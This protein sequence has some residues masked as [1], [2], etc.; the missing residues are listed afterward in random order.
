MVGALALAGSLGRDKL[1]IRLSK[2]IMASLFTKPTSVL[3]GWKVADGRYASETTLHGTPPAP[4]PLGLSLDLLV[5]TRSLP[6]FKKLFSW[7]AVKN[8]RR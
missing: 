3:D 5:I 7:H 4:P 1:G 6:F 8:N 2:W